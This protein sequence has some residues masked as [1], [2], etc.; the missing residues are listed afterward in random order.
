MS[1]SEHP[2]DVQESEIRATLSAVT[3][4]PR[5]R[6]RGELGEALGEEAGRRGIRGPRPSMLWVRAGSLLSVGA[7]LLTLAAGRL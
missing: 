2:S 5:G 1:P 6:W 4:D 7:L 3:P